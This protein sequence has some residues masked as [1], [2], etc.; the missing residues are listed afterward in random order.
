MKTIFLSSASAQNTNAF[1]TEHYS[2]FMGISLIILLFILFYFFIIP[3]KKKAKRL[4]NL[5]R[6]LKVGDKVD[7]LSGISGTIKELDSEYVIIVTG[8]KKNEVEILKTS[9]T[10]ICS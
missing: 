1:V 3:D 6:N 4:E 7:T 9:I 8:S 10:N 5:W 2:F